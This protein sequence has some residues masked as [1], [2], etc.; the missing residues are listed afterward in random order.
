MSRD[1]LQRAYELIKAGEKDQADSILQNIVVEDPENVQAWWLLANA[2]DNEARQRSA[3]RQV[4]RLDPTHAQARAM[5]QRLEDPLGDSFDDLYQESSPAAAPGQRV[6]VTKPAGGQ[7]RSCLIIFL[8][9]IVAACGLCTLSV[10]LIGG[11]LGSVIMEAIDDPEVRAALAAIT[12]YG[13][14]VTLPGNLDNRGPIEPG[15]TVTASISGG[16]QDQAWTF[17]GD[18]GE[19]FTIDVTSPEGSVD[20]VLFVYAP[21]GTLRGLDAN[22]GSGSRTVR[23]SITLSPGGQYTIVVS[24]FG[25][26][27]GEYEMTLERR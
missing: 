21:D 17:S 14:Y 5:Q 26:S 16:S 25:D 18:N 11:S 27:G 1:E 23:M 12:E 13:S 4:L 6:V 3:L 8:V 9:I 19:R 10:T 22:V 24:S 20:P 15:Q 2:S 7:N